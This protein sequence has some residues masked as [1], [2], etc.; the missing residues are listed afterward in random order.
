MNAVMTKSTD[1][2]RAYYGT[3]LPFT[4]TRDASARRTSG[5]AVT[6]CLFSRAETAWMV[7]NSDTTE[8]QM[9]AASRQL[10]SCLK[11]RVRAG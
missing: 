5:P 10:A 11:E 9:P 4:E 8:P 1:K 7:S 2:E 3:D 6:A